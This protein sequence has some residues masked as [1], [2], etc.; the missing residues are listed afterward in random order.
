[1]DDPFAL[2]SIDAVAVGMGRLTLDVIVRDAGG[3]GDWCTA[4]LLLRVG[5]GGR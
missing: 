1:M 4:G 2:P 3:S 5:Q